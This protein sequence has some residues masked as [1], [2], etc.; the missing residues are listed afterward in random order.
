MNLIPDKHPIADLGFKSASPINFAK[1]D[2]KW[3]WP[4]ENPITTGSNPLTVNV[5]RL[6]PVIFPGRVQVKGFSVLVSSTTAGAGTKIRLYV[7]NSQDGAPHTLELDLG[8]YAEFDG[9]TTGLKSIIYPFTFDGN[10]LYWF[11]INT[12]LTSGAVSISGIANLP[13]VIGVPDS[14]SGSVLPNSYSWLNGYT[15]VRGCLEISLLTP[16]AATILNPYPLVK[17]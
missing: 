11:G 4:L 7:Y 9:T 16:A 15:V 8:S 13:N 1:R 10:R 17:Y 5:L 12:N 2:G 3:H 6:V 14:Y